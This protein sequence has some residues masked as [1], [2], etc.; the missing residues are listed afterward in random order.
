MVLCGR[1]VSCTANMAHSQNKVQS[2]PDTVDDARAP[3]R[4]PE[5]LEDGAGL[6]KLA[7]CPPL[8]YNRAVDKFSDRGYKL[9]FSFPEMIGSL[10]KRTVPEDV[11]SQF[12][13]S[14][15]QKVSHT[16]VSE[17]FKARDSDV[18]W[19]VTVNGQTAYILILVELQSTVEPYM[20]LRVCEYEMHLY[21]D[22]LNQKLV[23]GL[24]PEIIPI[25]FY[26]GEQEW[27]A[28]LQLQALIRK[29]T[30]ALVRSTPHFE[31]YL[32]AV[33]QFSKEGQVEIQDL[34]DA[35]CALENSQVEEIPDLVERIVPVI[36]R[37]VN[38]RLQR[39][40]TL[41]M[42]RFL[43]KELP[44]D[45]EGFDLGAL[46]V[47]EAKHMLEKTIEEYK[48]KV[49]EEARKQALEEGCKATA[50]A[51]EEG[52]KATADAVLLHLETKF[53]DLPAAVR[54]RVESM[55]LVELKELSHQVRTTQGLSDLGLGTEQPR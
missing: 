32:V 18:L 10:I 26:T 17:R 23:S 2:L 16:F 30:P 38:T 31:Y 53:G 27:T 37:E 42:L 41:W 43:D 29:S 13:L 19:Q 9:L 47:L 7:P 8:L 24:L 15:L 6:A 28:P 44:E 33:N 12:N 35:A 4:C 3:W 39:A 36:G 48:K 22:L 14:S 46:D 40:F 49:Q 25:V 51:L 55:S 21:T 34:L 54:A 20:A 11:V 50:D 5:P 52:R 45:L 1:N